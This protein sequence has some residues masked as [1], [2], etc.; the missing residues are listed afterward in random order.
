MKTSI[1][2]PFLGHLSDTLVSLHLNSDQGYLF[3]SE[4]PID[5]PAN[6]FV[7]LNITTPD[8]FESM[9]RSIWYNPSKITVRMGFNSSAERNRDHFHE[10]L[11]PKFTA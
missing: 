11:P 5:D 3:F 10:H 9:I 2:H 8:W 6:S 4:P 7:V 1:Q